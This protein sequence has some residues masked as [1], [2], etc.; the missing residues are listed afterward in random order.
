[1][2]LIIIFGSEFSCIYSGMFM[3]FAFVSAIAVWLACSA[4][5]FTSHSINSLWLKKMN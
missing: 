2:L 3:F 4:M 5:T 1:M